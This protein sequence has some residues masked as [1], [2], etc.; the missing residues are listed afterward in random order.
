MAVVE[1]QLKQISFG[2]Y[3]NQSEAFYIAF[4]NKSDILFT[5]KQEILVY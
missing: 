1:K 4:D 2:L 3:K 5:R